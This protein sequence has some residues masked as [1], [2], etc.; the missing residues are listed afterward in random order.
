MSENVL[1]ISGG[2]DSTAMLLL[3]LERETENLTVVFADVGHE[4]P[5]TY[6]YLAYLEK[7]LGVNIK[8]VKADFTKRFEIKR[9]TVQT[10]WREEGVSEKI[11]DD[12]LSVLH[13]TGIPMLDVCLIMGRFPSTKTKFC[14]KFL[15]VNP[16]FDQ[17]FSPLMEEGKEIHSWQGV[18]AQES[19]A[20]SGLT[21]WEGTPEG[22]TIYRPI[23][24]W[25]VYDVFKYHD[26]HGI[27]PNPLY[28]E[29]MN[30]V[31]CMPCINS[32][33][34]ELFEIGRRYP[35]EIARLKEWETIVS[36]AS[37]QGSAT[38]FTSDNRGHGIE[39]IV[40]WSKTT[41]GG[42]AYDLTKLIEPVPM[43]SSQYG[44]C[45]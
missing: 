10:K 16:M 33:K 42:S 22:F 15:K 45:E 27:K 29:G 11:I 4:H 41:R 28:L 40:E 24:S 25:D 31:G 30:R 23:L 3:A 37:K 19:Q 36:K 26:K 7:E 17:V 44:L 2:K 38:F 13:P 35:E 12:A 14:T 6:E 39:E 32:R 43:C 21:E 1:S 20:R 8:R 34:S 9:K 5:K 18:R